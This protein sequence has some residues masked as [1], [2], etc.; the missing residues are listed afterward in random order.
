MKRNVKV[1]ILMF[2]IC[3][4][5]KGNLR[6]EENNV[7]KLEPAKK[8]NDKTFAT[9]LN[10]SYRQI[11]FYYFN[12]LNV[13]TQVFLQPNQTSDL[14]FDSAIYIVQ[15]NKF[16]N[17]YK[18][19]RK[20]TLEI[21][22]DEKEN[23]IFLN[24]KDQQEKND[25]NLFNYVNEHSKYSWS[26]FNNLMF[27][28]NTG[29]YKVADSLYNDRYTEQSFYL[30]EYYK[31][32][33]ISQKAKHFAGNYFR[34][35]LL[36]NL[37]SIAVMN[38]SNIPPPY[39]KYLDDFEKEVVN[40]T[41]NMDPN[42]HSPLFYSFLRYKMKYLLKDKNLNRILI[43]QI[44]KFNIT[45]QAKQEQK[46]YIISNEINF[47]RKI[48]SSV[49]KQFISD[50][51]NSEFSNYYQTLLT[52]IHRN[53]NVGDNALYK[54]DNSKVEYADIIKSL[55]GKVVFIDVWASWCV[56]CRRQFENSKNLQKYF[57]GKDV[58]FAFIS[59]DNSSD[60]WKK[61]CNEEG[62]SKKNLNFLLPNS[63]NSNLVKTLKINS[64]P[65]YIV[66]GKDG[67]IFNSD[68][69]EKINEETK[70][71]ITEALKR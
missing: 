66:V 20:D 26:D 46:N 35:Q 45:E 5:C 15:S 2:F 52:D 70:S 56:P 37:F 38:K 10:R 60:A 14:L 50:Y 54:V 28:L 3:C 55:K 31:K 57:S 68:L 11:D 29:N 71:V 8:L 23:I 34:D 9:F 49:L 42:I 69:S 18:I 27:K 40:K 43:S 64:I 62:I 63:N 48:D 25:I 12:K 22:T 16:Q 7:S 21:S 67:K 58:E 19:D 61:A 39:F 13:L 47:E 41:N 1:L 65:R 51:P 32:Y 24:I 30:E 59:L 44:D 53:K 33:P 17:I 6:K 4:S 36:M